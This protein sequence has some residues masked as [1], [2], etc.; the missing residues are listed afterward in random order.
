[1]EELLKKGGAGEPHPGAS[2]DRPVRVQE[3]LIKHLHPVLPGDPEVA[4]GEEAG[5]GVPGQVM[6]PALLP[7]LGHYGVNPWKSSLGIG[8]LGQSLTVTIPW[9]LQHIKAEPTKFNFD[10]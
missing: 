1:M 9:N 7:Q 3:E 2:V 10:L 6:Y 8:P 5:G 4:P